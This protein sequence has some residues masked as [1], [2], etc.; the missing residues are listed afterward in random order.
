MTESLKKSSWCHKQTFHKK[1]SHI[2]V[3]F[4]A[5]KANLTI[6]ILNYNLRNNLNPEYKPKCYK[7]HMILYILK[8]KEQNYVH[9]VVAKGIQNLIKENV[10]NKTKYFLKK[11]GRH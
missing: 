5:Q 4:S 11:E 3:C 9:C 8:H 6:K 10:R 2:T 7:S 1:N